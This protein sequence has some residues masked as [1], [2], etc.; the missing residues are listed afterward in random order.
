MIVRFHPAAY[1]ELQ[2]ALNWYD[3]RSP[4][5]AAAFEAEVASAIARI[6]E[7]PVR[8]PSA[9]HGTRRIILQQFPFNIYYLVGDMGIVVIAVA[10]QK[11]RPGYWRERIA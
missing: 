5:S 8:Y 11:R 3:E 4:L 10:H 2:A 7:A 1:G 6:T 9:D